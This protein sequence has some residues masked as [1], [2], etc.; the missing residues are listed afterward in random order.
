MEQL[1]FQGAYLTV[2]LIG[3]TLTIWFVD[4]YSRPKFLS[5]GVMLCVSTLICEAAIVANFV[6]S[7]NQNALG[8]GVA[9]FMLF[10]AFYS[11]FLD[12]TQFSYVGE[13]FPTHL[14]AKGLS[15]GVATI[16]FVNIIWLQ[17][18]PVGLEYVFDLCVTA[19][20]PNNAQRNNAIPNTIQKY[21]LA[22]LLRVHCYCQCGGGMLVVLLP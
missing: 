18:A 3:Q 16:C 10:L 14:R 6:P 20:H 13:I 8:A 21:W 5:V 2:G 7:T 19:R 4:H 12:G 9:M 1:C 22:I 15:S 11:F 17:A